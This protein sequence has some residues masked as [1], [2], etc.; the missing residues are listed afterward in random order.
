VLHPLPIVFVVVWVVNLG[1]LNGGDYSN[2]IS[3]FFCVL[4]IVLD[5][6]WIVFGVGEMSRCVTKLP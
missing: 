3:F 1:E 5:D 6:P 4:F 2:I